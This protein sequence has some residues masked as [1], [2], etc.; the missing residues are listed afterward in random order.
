[1]YDLSLFNIT[2]ASRVRDCVDDLVLRLS[3]IILRDRGGQIMRHVSTTS[4]QFSS[5]NLICM[6]D[7]GVLCS[8]RDPR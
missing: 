3:I 7:I 1:M 6:P 4:N 8:A 2:C 5:M